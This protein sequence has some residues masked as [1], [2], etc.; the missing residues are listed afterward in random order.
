MVV[1]SYVKRRGT[2]AD[3]TW[4]FQQRVGTV[5]ITMTSYTAAYGVIETRLI[6]GE[7]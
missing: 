7:E 3:A 5:R 1:R 4:R 6:N 2:R